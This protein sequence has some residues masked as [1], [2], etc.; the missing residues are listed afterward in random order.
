ME[1]SARKI[2]RSSFEQDSAVSTKFPQAM[3]RF[4]ATP[5]QALCDIQKGASD[6][7]EPSAASYAGSEIRRDTTQHLRAGLIN[8]AAPRLLHGW[9]NSFSH[10]QTISFKNVFTRIG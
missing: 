6:G 9:L 3:S 7:D 1:N 2:F 4:A 10:L 8:S 5:F